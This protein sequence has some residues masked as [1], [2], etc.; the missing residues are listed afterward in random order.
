MTALDGNK[1]RVPVS[2]NTSVSLGLDG[3]NLR[4]IPV[5]VAALI[6]GIPVLGTI[7]IG[8]LAGGG[9]TW[10][11]LT[12][13]FLWTYFSNTVVLIVLTG[14]LML[15]TAVPAAW[16][17]TMYTFPGRRIFSWAL[18]LPLAAPGYVLAI[19]YADFFGLFGPA[20][21]LLRDA[22][23]L[24]AR[25]YW[26]PDIRSLPGLAFVMAAALYP[27]VYLTSRAAF[28][29]QSVC[30]LEAARALGMRSS[31]RFWRV[32][33]PSARPAIAAGCALALMETAADY[34]AADFL[35]VQTLTVGVFRAWASFGD[36]A[37][38][39]RLALV[40]L[41]F[42]LFLQWL[43]RRQ[44]GQAGF[45][46]NAKGW[47]QLSSE[48]IHGPKAFLATLF[49]LSVLAWGFLLPMGHMALVALDAANQ[50]PP[51]G[52]ALWNSVRLAGIGA[53]AAFL[54]ALII[55]FAA[56]RGRWIGQMAQA[57]TTGGYAI[58]GAVL[59]L[60]ALYTLDTLGLPL[61]GSAALFLL[62][63]VYVSRFTAAGAQPMEAALSR[64]PVSFEHAARSLGASPLSRLRHVD[65]P[66]L[67]PGAAASALILFVE[68]LKE[69][70]A[71]LMLR[72]FNWDTL[73]VKA[74]AYASDERLGAAAAPSL[75]ITLAGLLPVI[76]L[77]WRLSADQLEPS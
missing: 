46:K 9:E 67:L 5:G 29:T 7:L 8:I 25:D 52:D 56:H 14:A 50:A 31:L 68:I 57:V 49:C 26:F 11:H 59:A 38:G 17:V 36:A 75:M 34:G 39:A 44:R 22:T 10:T 53:L 45:E 47:R 21:S 13:T 1:A 72:P 76:L 51:L 41:A 70:P 42:T 16:L 61:S 15:L 71:T 23:G 18:I 55:G 20:Q 63:L 24:A 54:I 66:V 37:A 48:P 6:V 35:G 19:S 64:V 12:Q 58:P 28:M 65:L 69:L 43:E 2:R 73:A 33:L 40:L 74:F 27:Y 62:V 3:L 32:A 4:D 77:S 60:G 30:A